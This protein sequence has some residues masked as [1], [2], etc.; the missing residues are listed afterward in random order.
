MDLFLLLLQISLSGAFSVIYLLLIRMILGKIPK[1]VTY[2]LW[3]LVAFHFIS[4]VKPKFIIAVIPDIDIVDWLSNAHVK[5]NVVEVIYITGMAVLLTINLVQYY[6][7][8]LKLKRNAVQV[9]ISNGVRIYRCHGGSSAFTFGFLPPR[10]YLPEGLDEESEKLIVLHEKIHIRRGDYLVKLIASVLCVINWYNPFVWIAF[11]FFS[12]DQEASCDELVLKE[13]GAEFK[14]KYANIIFQAASGF[15]VSGDNDHVLAFGEAN[16]K[17]RVRR[18]VKLEETSKSVFVFGAL[19]TLAAFLLGITVS[20]KFKITLNSIKYNETFAGIYDDN[21]ENEDENEAE[22]EAKDDDPGIMLETIVAVT[23][24]SYEKRTNGIYLVADGKEE[25]LVKEKYTESDSFIYS[26]EGVLFMTDKGKAIQRYDIHTHKLEKVYECEDGK[27]VSKF[28][29]SRGILE[30]KY[31]DA[32]TETVKLSVK[33]KVAATGE[34][35]LSNKGKIYNVT[36]WMDDYACA[37]LDLDSDGTDERIVLDFSLKDIE[38]IGTTTI[39]LSVGS[40]SLKEQVSNVANNIYAFSPDGRQILILTSYMIKNDLSEENEW[41]TE[42]YRYKDSLVSCGRLKTEVNRIRIEDENIIYSESANIILSGRKKRTFKFDSEGNL[43]EEKSDYIDIDNARFQLGRELVVHE[44]P[45][46]GNTFSV[47]A[48]SVDIC[49][50][51]NECMWSIGST[52]YRGYWVELTCQD[53]NKGW[54]F[55]SDGIL[56][57]TGVNAKDVFSAGVYYHNGTV[58]NS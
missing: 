8:Y 31:S 14:K 16:I 24:E 15:F 41:Y 5:W 37:F 42:I 4:P 28:T 55:V 20:D 33:E 50:A 22:S 49:K 39:S 21:T 47:E 19:L 1:K 10:I 30:V 32:S 27:S 18:L 35:V 36:M 44:Y 9:N 23:G 11:F 29:V 17:Y 56:P 52:K 46:S 51:T 26:D 40:T 38:S 12:R 53:G 54:I 45:E 57:E 43:C 3:G 58:G 25:L 13:V 34:T 2:A 7:V 6:R 48:Q